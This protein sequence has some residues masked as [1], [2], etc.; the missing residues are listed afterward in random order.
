MNEKTN[1]I[2]KKENYM[3]EQPKTFKEQLAESRAKYAAQPFYK[4][5]LHNISSFL[6]YKLPRKADY[7]AAKKYPLEKEHREVGFTYWDRPTKRYDLYEVY[8][9]IAWT[10]YP[11]LVRF[12]RAEKMGVPSDFVDEAGGI[13][14]VAWLEVIDKMIY[15]FYE[16]LCD[17]NFL[18][19]E[20]V[21]SKITEGLTLFAKYFQNLW[22]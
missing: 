3:N 20:E 1:L 21:Q 19:E 4:K 17:D 6:F 16:I 9:S 8:Y 18:L 11:K 12:R 13:N 15:A 2:I 7:I 10:I 5:A 14:E 22:D